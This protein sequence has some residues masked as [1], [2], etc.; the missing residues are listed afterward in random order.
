MSAGAAVVVVA[1]AA[2]VLGAA[3]RPRPAPRSLAPAR[4]VRRRRRRHPDEQLEPLIVLLDAV[5]RELRAGDSLGSATARALRASPDVLP[6]VARGLD[7]GMPLADAL[8]TSAVADLHEH[9]RL[10][11][12]TLASAASSGGHLAP[13]VERAGVVLRERRAWVEER[14]AQSAPA[15]LGAS[16]MTVL[17]PAFGAWGVLSSASVRHA[18]A[19][20]PAPIACALVGAL[21]NLAGWWW[22][23]RI[24]DGVGR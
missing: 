17:P 23:R 22:M 15:R 13:P 2:V 24:I 12:Q 7:A 14:R 9:Q 16:V 19:T 21:A 11:V 6:T 10:V 4:R 8:T 3:C 5:A 20:S 18:Y 1:V